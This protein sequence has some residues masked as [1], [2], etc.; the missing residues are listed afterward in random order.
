MNTALSRRESNVFERLQATNAFGPEAIAKLDDG[1]TRDLI[2]AILKTRI[3][4]V[5]TRV[6]ESG[7]TTSPNTA[8]Y[9]DRLSLAIDLFRRLA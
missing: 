3:S 7:S 1:D 5:E 9:L 8:D 4:A 2:V 6:A